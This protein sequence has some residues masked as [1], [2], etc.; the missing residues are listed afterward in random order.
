VTREHAERIV[1]DM[2][3]ALEVQNDG[4]RKQLLSSLAYADRVMR[5]MGE[6]TTDTVPVSWEAVNQFTKEKTSVSLPR[7]RVGDTVIAE[8]RDPEKPSPLVDDI[9]AGAGGTAT[10]FQRMNEAGD[11]LRIATT[12]RNAQGERAVGTYIP[13]VNP[14]GQP[15]PVIAAVTRGETYVGRAV[16]VDTWYQTAYKPITR[17][18]GYVMGMLYVGIPEGTQKFAEVLTRIRLGESGYPFVI[19]S[20]GT[21]LVHPKQEVIGKNIITDIGLEMF[22]PVLEARKADSIGWMTYAYEGRPKFAA[23]GYFEPWDWIVCVSGYADEMNRKNAEIMKALFQGQ[24]ESTAKLAVKTAD[25]REMPL[26]NQVRYLDAEGREVLVIADGQAVD[27]SRLGSRKGVDWFEAACKGAPGSVLISR[28][29]IS[30]NTGKPEKRLSAPVYMDNHLEG[31]VVLNLNWAIMQDMQ[32]AQKVGKSGYGFML[33]PAGTVVCHPRW[34]LAD[35]VNLAHSNEVELARMVK[36]HMLKGE[37]GVD[38]IAMEG[39]R[40]I[41]AYAPVPMGGT[42]YPVA[43]I[44]PEEEMQETIDSLRGLGE[45]IL[46]QVVL[47]LLGILILVMAVVV[48]VALAV[49]GRIN[50]RLSALAS[51]LDS[52]AEQTS[53]AAG[54]VAQLSRSLAE[55]ASTQASSLEETSASLEE[56]ASMVRQNADNAAQAAALMNKTREVVAQ[57]DQA[58]QEL[59]RAMDEIKQSSDASA[60]IIK[61]IDEIA[62]QTNLLALNAAVEAARAGEAGRG[63]AVVAEEVRSLAQRSAEASRQTAEMIESSVRSADN[64]VEVAQRVADSLRATVENA[65]RVGQLIR[66][67]AAASQEQSQGIDQINK[68]VSQLD[69]VTQQNAASAEESAS[70]AQQLTAQAEAL[71]RLVAELKA[72]VGGAGV[73]AD[74]PTGPLALP[75]SS[76]HGAVR[77]VGAASSAAPSRTLPAPRRPQPPAKRPAPAGPPV[78]RREDKPAAKPDN[79]VRPEEVIPLDDDDLKDF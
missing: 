19:D 50:R 43:M 10:L 35:N 48:G 3:L 33:D 42:V 53:S 46:R 70:A 4:T 9:V 37:K 69:Q 63:F 30:K 5:E 21:T 77:R 71:T 26:Y 76:A 28:V 40:W 2:L 29:E 52:N 14:D 6:F 59:S 55:G 8:N 12:V 24:L 13:A 64:G 22:R 31:V 78:R 54:Q 56:A 15:N 47:M 57:M 1:R 65:E 25:G 67:I 34:G 23:Y 32:A 17:P 49:S 39:K 51:V 75:E 16:V 58:V 68:A 27:P 44:V 72:M 62:F 66:E 79:M 61:T 36:E 38:V 11:M 7:V 18:D 45:A 74:R 41:T 20:K 73:S 60:K